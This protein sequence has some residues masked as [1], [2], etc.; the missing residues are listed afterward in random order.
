LALLSRAAS[1]I[2]RDRG[3]RAAALNI[4]EQDCP[5]FSDDEDFEMRHWA[6]M[7]RADVVITAEGP[8]FIEFN[9]SG[10]FEGLLDFATHLEA[11]QRIRELTGRPAFVAVDPFPGFA[12]LIQRTCAEFNVPPAVVFVG[13]RRILGAEV[14][15]RFYSKET[16]LL[17][18][19]GVLAEHLEF[20]EL[21]DG[22]G[23][24]GKLRK[25]LGVFDFTA[26]EARAEGYDLSPVREALQ[27]G[28]RLIPSQS[29]LFLH[30]KKLLAILSEGMLWMTPRDRELVDRYVPWSRVVGDRAVTWRGERY[31]LPKL[32]MEQ[33]E[34]MVIKGANTDSG[35]EVFFGS[36][37]DP[38]DWAE[39]VDSALPTGYFVVQ[40]VVRSEQFPVDVDVDGTVTRIEAD[41]VVSPF[42]LGGVPSG[43]SLKFLPHLAPRVVSI[44]QG[45]FSGC[46]FAEP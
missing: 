4:M 43:C 35:T 15:A 6:D 12:A 19:H 40:E 22:I 33:Q 26:D 3:G 5:A 44:S 32:L 25:P 46:L 23:L 45:A 8:K 34:H 30:S 41:A 21:L 29:A 18:R 39:L 1:E 16:A 17:R 2:A 9:V 7:A 20:E 14:N 11:W 31:D 28:F 37:T 36:H 38:A 27:A 13:T 24:P 10:A 42:C